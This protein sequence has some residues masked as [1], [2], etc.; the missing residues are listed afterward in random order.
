MESIIKTY[1][2]KDWEYYLALTL[3]VI[4]TLAVIAMALR[5]FGLIQMRDKLTFSVTLLDFILILMTATWIIVRIQDTAFIDLL[6][7]LIYVTLNI[8]ALILNM[9]QLNRKE[10]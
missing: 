9:R 2:L 8:F 7:S 6:Y 10:L 5:V 1:G 4:G 3:S